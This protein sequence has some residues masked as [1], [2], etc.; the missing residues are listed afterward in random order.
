MLLEYLC[1]TAQI[2]RRQ[3]AQMASR[4]RPDSNLC[5]GLLP[6]VEW[7]VLRNV[8]FRQDDEHRAAVVT[9]GEPPAGI[10]IGC[11]QAPGAIIVRNTR[12]IDRRIC[13]W[14]CGW[15]AGRYFPP[16]NWRRCD[17]GQEID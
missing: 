10:A 4:H 7:F 14:L 1:Q 15:S 8:F 6:A 9:H 11:E 17:H 5:C 12:K 13:A 2:A 16:D 3:H